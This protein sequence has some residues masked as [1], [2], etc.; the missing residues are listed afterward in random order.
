MPQINYA[1]FETTN[2]CNLKCSFCS[3]RSSCRI[4]S[5]HISLKD[6]DKILNKVKNEPIKNIKLTGLGEPFLHPEFNQI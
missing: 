4:W 2:Y 5:F 3:E 1:C 6:W